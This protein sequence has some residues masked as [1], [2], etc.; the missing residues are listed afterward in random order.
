[1]Q[2]HESSFAW[3]QAEFGDAELG[4]V[5]RTARLVQVVARAVQNPSGKLSEVFRSPR[6]LDAAYDFVERAQTTVQALQ[7]T[8]GRATARACEG[9]Y[10]FVAVDGSSVNLTD[11]GGK[12]DFGSIGTI[13]AG[14][15]GLKVM[16]ALA[17][18]AD[19]CPVGVLHQAWWARPPAKKRTAKQKKADRQ[20]RTVDE[21]ETRHWLETIKRAAEHLDA[22]NKRAWFQLDREA[23][24]WPMLQ[25]LAASGHRFTVRSAWD[26]IVEATGR[27]RQYLRAT[28][29]ASQPVGSYELNVAGQTGR[30]ARTARMIMRC[31]RVTLL[32]RDKRS[33]KRQPFAVNVVWVNESGTTPSDEKPIDWMLLTNADIDTVEAV[34]LVVLGYSMRWRI[35]E[36]H[37]TW[38]T[39]RCN[40]ELTQLRSR[41]AVIRWATILA[42]AATRIERLKYLAR[43][44]PERPATD[45]LSPTEI[46]VILVLKRLEK[47]RTETVGRGTPTMAQALR[48]LADLGGYTG[49]S[50][51]GPPGSIT[52]GRGLKRVQEASVVVLAMRAEE[53]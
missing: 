2:T 15:R 22:V 32:L 37:K 47:K 19:G 49:K 46:E 6:E 5:R 21:K 48:W 36:F 10:V 17:V 1:M 34:R 42:V 20:R 7:N 50:S 13:S 31:A 45:E 24:A 44:T 40:V 26:R 51:G 8:V 9:S 29:K 39:G 23:D 3:A 18:D 12:K 25:T 11:A 35:E 41:D 38:K 4:D 27:D 33:K 53:K 28:L 14:A 30:K 16:N 43:T 52:I